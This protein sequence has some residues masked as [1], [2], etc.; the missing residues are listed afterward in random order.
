MDRRNVV[1]SVAE[2]APCFK[3]HRD[4]G[5]FADVG[6]AGRRPC[7]AGVFARSNSTGLGAVDLGYIHR[8]GGDRGWDVYYSSQCPC[9]ERGIS[10][11][12]ATDA[13][14]RGQY[15]GFASWPTAI[16]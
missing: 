10:V 4:V 14:R 13:A 7:S 1:V 8:S 6:L 16:E 11:E 5:R 9:S 12:N 2:F 3:Y 15:V